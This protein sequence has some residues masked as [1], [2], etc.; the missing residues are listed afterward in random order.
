MNKCRTITRKYKKSSDEEK[1]IIKAEKKRETRL[2][3]Y[4][5]HR[6]EILQ[7]Q[8]QPYTCYCGAIL[9][10]HHKFRHLQ[11]HKHIDFDES[12]NYVFIKNI[13]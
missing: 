11:T 12:N 4:D 13:F 1:K 7:K 6:E 5:H 2:R 3:Y 8:S 9:T 10:I